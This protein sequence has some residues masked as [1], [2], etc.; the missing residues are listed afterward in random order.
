MAP[1]G[2]AL[3]TASIYPPYQAAA[4]DGQDASPGLSLV[5]ARH[6]HNRKMSYIFRKAA[7]GGSEQNADKP[8]CDEKSQVHSPCIP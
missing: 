8:F 4:E 7:K 5:A 2:L 3:S 1:I 6:V